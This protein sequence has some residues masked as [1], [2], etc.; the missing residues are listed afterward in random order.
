VEA[1]F[2]EGKEPQVLKRGKT[3][4]QKSEEKK[5]DS[6]EVV[7][8]F[9]SFLPLAF[10]HFVDEGEKNL[11]RPTSPLMSEVVAIS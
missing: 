10:I 7:F 2:H 11:A 4:G 5:P 6:P 3:I 9:F 8:L 1:H